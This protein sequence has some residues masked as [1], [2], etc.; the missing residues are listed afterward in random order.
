[1][2]PDKRRR[3]AAAHRSTGDVLAG[4]RAGSAQLAPHQ[5]HQG[6]VGVDALLVD[7]VRRGPVPH[8]AALIPTAAERPPQHRAVTAIG[9]RAGLGR[10]G[11]DRLIEP[12]RLE[13]PQHVVLQLLVRAPAVLAAGLELR[14]ELLELKLGELQSPPPQAALSAACDGVQPGVCVAARRVHGAAQTGRSHHVEGLVGGA[15]VVVRRARQPRGHRQERGTRCLRLHRADLSNQLRHRLGAPTTDARK[16]ARQRD[17]AQLF[18]AVR[19]I[20]RPRRVPQLSGSAD[21]ATRTA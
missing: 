9:E 17:R 19:P 18:P 4:Q 5:L 15:H 7:D 10:G 2:P 11:S 6:A 16:L 8:L 3:C 20:P 12:A 21:C 14:P 13:P 1:M